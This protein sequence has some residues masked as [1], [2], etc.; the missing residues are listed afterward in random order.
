MP[1]PE[2]C[3]RPSVDD[4]AVNL[5]PSS[6]TLE[7]RNKVNEMRLKYCLQCKSRE[8][9]RIDGKPF[10]RCT[11]ENC[12][13]IYSDCINEVAMSRFLEHNRLSPLRKTDSALELCYPAM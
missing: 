7:S 13:S 12:L 11:K 9:V 1:H 3:P 2:R 5:C 4:L 10:S 8:E 6:P